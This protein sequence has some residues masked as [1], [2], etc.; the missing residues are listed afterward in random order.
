MYWLLIPAASQV[1]TPGKKIQ[2]E[3]EEGC[4]TQ[5]L[6][7]EFVF[8]GPNDG[9]FPKGRRKGGRED[10]II[11]KILVNYHLNKQLLN[12]IN[13]KVCGPQ[14]TYVMLPTPVSSQQ[15]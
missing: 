11:Y 12:Y 3:E 7:L 14:N 10:E 1:S 2:K 9:K 5:C 15:V 8:L 13:Y 4:Q 6:I